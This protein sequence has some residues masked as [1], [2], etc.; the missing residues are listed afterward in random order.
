MSAFNPF[1]FSGINL[2][3]PA[4][5]GGGGGGSLSIGDAIGSAT[6]NSLL[7]IDGAGNL[8]ALGPLTNGQLIIGSTGGAAVAGALSGTNAQITVLN[9]PGHITLSLPQNIAMASSPTF[10]NI[11][12]SFWTVPGLMKNNSSGVLASGLLIDSDI[13]TNAG[14]SWH[15]LAAMSSSMPAK[16]DNS[17]FLTTGLIDLFDEVTGTLAVSKGGTGSSVA[18]TANKVMVS[19]ANSIIES[20][21]TITE[22]NGLAGVS[23]PVAEQLYH[24]ERF[25]LTPLDISNKYVTLAL[26]PVTPSNTNLYIG[27]GLYQDYGV[28][29]TVSGTQLSWNGLGLDGI[30]H[31]GDKLLVQYN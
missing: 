24:V 22:L 30:L 29:F 25:T 13:D 10:S 19:T 2:V 16:T 8:D 12:L 15:K 4:S 3:N 27:G 31:A 28:D 23:G 20:A 18:L 14:I 21:V 26:A 1:I 5:G 11:T 9:S 6:P 7:R 17:G